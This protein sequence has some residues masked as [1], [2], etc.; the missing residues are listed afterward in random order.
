MEKEREMI[1]A[2]EAARRLGISRAS[3]SRLI[4]NNCIGVYR[5]GGKTMFDETILDAYKKSVFVQPLA[6]RG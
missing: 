2:K 1:S 4:R 6:E 5:V 3:L